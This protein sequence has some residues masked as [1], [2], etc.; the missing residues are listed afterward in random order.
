MINE[1]TCI[2]VVSRTCRLFPRFITAPE[3]I[4]DVYVALMDGMLANDAGI[5]RIVDALET[6]DRGTL[7]HATGDVLRT[8]HWFSSENG[9]SIGAILM[10]ENGAS[11][12]QVEDL[13]IPGDFVKTLQRVLAPHF[14]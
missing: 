8:H 13:V 3:A 4:R 7:L 14:E 2:K 12:K 5:R 1:S 6:S 9:Y 10:T 11:V